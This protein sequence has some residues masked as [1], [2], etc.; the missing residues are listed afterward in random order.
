MD[1]PYDRAALLFMLTRDEVDTLL[2][3]HP[4]LQAVVFHGDKRYAG[5][6]DMSHAKWAI[7]TAGWRGARIDIVRVE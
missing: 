2:R 3:A 6:R 1:R 4:T 5:F 7:E